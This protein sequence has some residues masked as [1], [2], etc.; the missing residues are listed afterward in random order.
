MET[1]PPFHTNPVELH[2]AVT[3]EGHLSINQDAKA[4]YALMNSGNSSP[5]VADDGDYA[6]YR[7]TDGLVYPMIQ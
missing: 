6:F 7:P 4:P 5:R 2:I 3:T 1:P